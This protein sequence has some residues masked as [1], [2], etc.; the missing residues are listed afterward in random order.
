MK[1]YRNFIL[2]NND[3]F[4]VQASFA[5][6]SSEV[7]YKCHEMQYPSKKPLTNHIDVLKILNNHLAQILQW[8]K[9]GTA[10]SIYY[11]LIPPKTCKIIK[12]KLYKQWIETGQYN[13]GV[14]LKPEEIAQWKIFDVLYKK[15]FAD[16]AFKPNNIY[17]SKNVNKNYKHIVFT[18]N[19]IDKMYV[20][21][22]KLEESNKIK[23]IDDLL[24]HSN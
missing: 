19:T 21:L 8:K 18:K 11:M 12:E 24:R 4:I 5:N 17:N 22:D 13:S 20:Y 9:D 1:E 7:V 10:L 6:C 16:I 23:T 14:K 2:I 3:S 15:T